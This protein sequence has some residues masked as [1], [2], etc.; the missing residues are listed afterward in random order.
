MYIIHGS[1]QGIDVERAIALDTRYF[2]RIGGVAAKE[3]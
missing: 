3:R 2:D 1:D